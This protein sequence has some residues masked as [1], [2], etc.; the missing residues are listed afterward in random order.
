MHRPLIDTCELKF[1]S[2][3]DAD[4]FLV[5]QV[6]WKSINNFFYIFLN[7]FL[8]IYFFILKAYWRSCSFVLGYILETAFRDE[9]PVV[10]HSWPSANCRIYTIKFHNRKRNILIFFVKFS[11][12]T[13]VVLF[14]MLKLEWKDGNLQKYNTTLYIIVQFFQW[15]LII[16][17]KLGWIENFELRSCWTITCKRFTVR[18]F[19]SWY[20]SGRKNFRRQSVKTFL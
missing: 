2:Y 17:K 10:L 19:G 3:S 14:M 20:V 1:L 13:K 6:K 8:F 9:F 11:Q 16:F 5:N 18:T 4:C 7:L 15:L 12:I